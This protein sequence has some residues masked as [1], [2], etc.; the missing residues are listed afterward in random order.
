MCRCCVQADIEQT[1]ERCPRWMGVFTARYELLG[2]CPWPLYREVFATMVARGLLIETVDEHAGFSRFMLA[3]L[4]PLP[5]RKGS[6][7]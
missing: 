7:S 5:T 6:D 3:R 2:S 4:V 1:W